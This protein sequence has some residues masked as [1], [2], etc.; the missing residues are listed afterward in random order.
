MA[1]FVVP[2][3]NR[4]PHFEQETTLDGVRFIL[5]FHWNSVSGSW[6][7]SVSDIDGE[8]IISGRRMSANWSMLARS[9]DSRRPAGELIVIDTSGSGVDPSFD[10]LGERV[11]LSY[12]EAETVEAL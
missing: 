9:A 12:L 4:N 1:V 3:A 11:L 8:P 6:F 10:E 2:T 5:N 7:M